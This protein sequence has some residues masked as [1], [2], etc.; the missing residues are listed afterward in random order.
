M[1]RRFTSLGILSL[2]LMGGLAY[3]QVKGV[4]KDSNGFP[5]EE[6]EIIV[7]RTGTSVFTD[8]DGNFNV[9]AK[10]GDTLKIIDSNGEEKTI[11]VTSNT[12]GDVKFTTKASENI[13][14]GTVNLVGGIKMDAA[15][16]IGAYDIVKKEDFEL[17]PTASIDEVLNG[18]VAGL[19]FSSNSGDPGS[20]NIITIRGVGSLVGTPNPLY[21]IDGVV[22]GKGSDNAS[23]MESWNPLAAIDPNAV[24]SVSVLKDAS[25]TALYGARGANGVIV[26]T[27]KKGRYN[28]KTRFNLSTDMAVQDIAFNNQRFMNANEVI[29]WGTLAN[30]NTGNYA[31]MDAARDYTI[32]NQYQYDGVTNTDWQKVITRNQSTVKTYN[33]SAAGGGEN[34]S[35]RIGGSYY[36]NSPLIINSKFDRVSLNS[37]VDHKVEDKLTLGLNLNFTNVTRKTVTDGGAYA[38]PWN[39]RWNNLPLYPVYNTDGTLNQN[40]PPR[41]PNETGPLTRRFNPLGILEN[42]FLK[43][44]IAT[45]LGSINAEWQFAKNFYLFSLFGTQ[46]QTLSEKSYWDPS[47][48][49][50]YGNNG[51]VQVGKTNIFDWNWQNSVSYR[52]KFN[53]VHDLQ[54]WAGMEYQEHKY[55]LLYGSGIDLSEPKPFLNFA[56]SEKVSTEEELLMW[57][58]ISYF[59]RL[60]YVYN[61]KYTL[62]AQ[63]RKDSNSTLGVNDKSGIFWSVGGSW[64]LAKEFTS[65]PMSKLLVRANYG[66]IGNIPYADSWGKNV[67]YNA[68]TKLTIGNYGADPT[69]GITT[70]G[71]PDLTWEISKQ[72]NAGVDFGFFNDKLNFSVD[73]YNKLTTQ[74]IYSFGLPNTVGGPDSRL[75]NIGDISNKGIEVTINAAPISTQGG[76]RWGIYGNFSYNRNKVEK[77]FEQ[78]GTFELDATS[79]NMRG[80]A[81]GREVG[82]YYTFLWAGVDPVTGA[83]RWWKDDSKKEYAY[84]RTEASRVWMGKSAFPKYISSLKHDFSYKNVTLSVFFTGQFDFYVHNRWQNF[85]MS[86]GASMGTTHLTDALYDVWSPQNPNASNP[87]P[88]AGGI[89]YEGRAT[90]SD[91]PSTRWL[92]KGDHIRLKEVKLAY[93]FGDKFKQQT[94]LDNL[95]IY[96]KGVN[97][98][99][100]AFDKDLTFDPESNSNDGAGWRGKGLYDNTSPIMRSVSLGVVI[101]F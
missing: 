46:Y 25:A 7:T 76:F 38:N 98:W 67:N 64:N 68:Y 11:K 88:V 62:S 82:E 21:V 92:Y 53:E 8:G 31:T 4:L 32:K 58:Q 13:E 79:N 40:I 23:L 90:A 87:S 1:R 45:F 16:K 65:F 35:F 5:M 34:T 24:E 96:A 77:L 18:R 22:V 3:A 72:W 59:S 49:D 63:L 95:T 99:L 86:D 26:I 27:T 41:D 91:G 52:N 89:R 60:N 66:E 70:A 19:V 56:N 71:D 33:F 81:E 44:N 37:A 85:Q 78:E 97:L 61:S 93:S 29:E 83:P 54:V 100:W 55:N 15:Q 42:D 73:V 57:R 69:M 47:V 36:E 84:V 12:L 48:G 80:L 50:G 39:S 74:T 9:D 14:L 94:G 75:T 2:F 30:F 6:A 51:V 101:D 20:T 28:Q 10:V 43:G 17:A